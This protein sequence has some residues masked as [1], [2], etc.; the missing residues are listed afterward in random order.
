MYYIVSFELNGPLVI[1]KLTH[2]NWF[3]PD[4]SQAEIVTR[5]CQDKVPA[6]LVEKGCKHMD[7]GRNSFGV[8]NMR[9]CL[10]DTKNCNDIVY[11]FGSTPDPTSKPEVTS[12][13]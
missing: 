7:E 6:N 13:F 4:G 2:L 3:L 9:G 11:R 5:S 1:V 12:N 8:F 10:C